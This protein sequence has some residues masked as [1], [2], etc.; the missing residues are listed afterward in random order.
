VLDTIPGIGDETRIALLKKFGSVDVIVR[1]SDEEL[2]EMLSES[3]IG[4]LRNALE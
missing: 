1:A 4:L 2:A 3:Q